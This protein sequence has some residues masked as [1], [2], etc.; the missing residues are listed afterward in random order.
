MRSKLLISATTLLSFCVLFPLSLNAGG[1]PFIFPAPP[2]VAS[3]LGRSI[4]GIVQGV[5]TLTQDGDSKAELMVVQE[6]INT[7]ADGT[8][9]DTPNP[10]SDGSVTQTPLENTAYDY[11]KA[12]I[13]DRT[14]LTTYGKL[15]TALS[16]SSKGAHA[17][18]VCEELNWKAG[19]KGKETCQA[20]VDTFF[21]K[22]GAT[23]REMEKIQ[24][25]RQAYAS[26]VV[27]R[28]IT[29]GYETQQKLKADLQAAAVAPV[30]ADNEIASIANDGQTLDE[31]LKIT[32]ADLAL[33]V[34]MM[35]ADAMGFMLQQPVAM[36]PKEKPTN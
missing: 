29:L 31:M 12:Q 5:L 33:Q 17:V 20:V 10:C 22:T 35:E 27:P 30:A 4:T 36:M 28:F 7:N 14:D 32:V 2:P 23:D 1:T 34:E 3:D 18:S 8:G 26:T 24:S 21:T 25:Q 6:Q 15:Q 11:I 19:G 13:L 9:D 16:S